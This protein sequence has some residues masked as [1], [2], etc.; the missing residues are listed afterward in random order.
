MS[1]DATPAPEPEPEGKRGLRRWLGE[2]STGVK[3][4][5]ALAGAVAAILGL[6]FLFFPDWV[7]DPTPGEGSAAFG[8]PTIE[9]PVTYGQYLDR[10]EIPR[11]T[12][13]PAELS[14]A[15][16]MF[17]AQLSISGYKDEELPLRWYVLDEST[18]EIV[19]QTS[20]RHLFR[21]DRDE[22][23]FSQRFWVA[24]PPGPGPFK[25]VL[26]IY[27]PGAKPGDGH[28]PLDEAETA[29]FPS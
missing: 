7:P 18:N 29:T 17:R 28:V 19:D 21:P 24:Q 11:D 27:P 22:V 9:H 20:R 25:V 23:Q 14:R 5:G 3:T 6:V 2:L 16:A 4:A 15:G 26:Q 13:T 8:E 12:S 1:A 10:V